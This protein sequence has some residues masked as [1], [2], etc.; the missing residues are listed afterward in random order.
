MRCALCRC[1]FKK[2]RGG[3]KYVA[4]SDCASMR[5]TDLL[6]SVALERGAKAE[7]LYAMRRATKTEGRFQDAI[8]LLLRRLPAPPGSK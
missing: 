6:V 7:D 3:E 4:C 2:S 1:R 5:G 8:G